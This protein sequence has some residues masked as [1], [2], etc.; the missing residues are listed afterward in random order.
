MR[1]YQ[2]VKIA[3]RVVF[4]LALGILVVGCGRVQSSAAFM[5]PVQADGEMVNVEIDPGATVREAIDQAGFEVGALDKSDPPFY[6]ILQS[7][8]TVVLTRV[9]EEYVVE[10]SVIPYDTQVLR[11]ESLAEGE[12]RLIQPG[13]NGLQETTFRVMYED[14]VETSRTISGTLIVNEPTPEILMIGSQAPFSVLPI[15]GILAYL[16]AGNGWIMRENTGVREPI[17]TTGDLD[18]RVFSLSPDGRW[19]LYSRSGDEEEAI[20]TLWVAKIDAEE[21]LEYDLG[22][23][24]IIHFASWIPGTKTGIIYSTAEVNPGPPGWQAN[25]DLYTLS[26]SEDTG[27]TTSPRVSLESNSGGLYGWWGTDFVYNVDGEQLA[28]TRPD[29]F[30]VVNL[31][32]DLMNELVAALPVQT[33]SDWAWIPP[34]DWSPDTNFIYF[35]EHAPQ[36][37]VAVD[38][39]SQVFNLS[40][41]PFVGG[42]PV[43]IVLDVGMF[44][45]PKTSPLRAEPSGEESFQVAFLQALSPRQSRASLYQLMVMDR[46]GSNLRRVF[47]DEAGQ[48]FSPNDYYWLPWYAVEE[49]PFYIALIN[50]GDLWLVDADTG[51]AVQLTEGG[52]VTA[53]DWN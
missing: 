7:G 34:V 19:L 3:V 2:L 38:E 31:D 26:F 33:R 43:P 24:N 11:N 45:Y 15:P 35:V 14:G 6:S 16:S 12:Q 8:D 1:L 42:A 52:L 29:G 46:D 47:P 21:I 9:E 18:G 53:L 5:V 30:G 39:D 13:A 22:V 20:N 36:E 10:Q 27:W 44:A 4:F 25:N 17:V 48:G 37:G 40:V 50:Q 51:E 28:Y 49:Y 32:Y 23:E 41:Y